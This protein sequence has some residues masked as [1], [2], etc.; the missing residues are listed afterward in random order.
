M[1]IKEALHRFR[2]EQKQRSRVRLKH[3]SAKPVYSC[4]A[5][6]THRKA[7]LHRNGPKLH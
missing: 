4:E 5:I 3:E 2:D 6:N 7:K 1:S